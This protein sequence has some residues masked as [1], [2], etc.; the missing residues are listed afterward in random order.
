MLNEIKTGE[1]T[2]GIKVALYYIQDMTDCTQISRHEA[3]FKF[4]I[5]APLK[6]GRML[7]RGSANRLGRRK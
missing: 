7:I 1:K 6:V 4:E 2:V 3:H 5:L